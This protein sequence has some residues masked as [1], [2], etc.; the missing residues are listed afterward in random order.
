[1]TAETATSRITPVLSPDDQRR[2]IPVSEAA[3]IIG[4]TPRTLRTWWR[5]GKLAGKEPGRGL[6][7]SREW[8][9]DFVGWEKAS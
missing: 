5:A 8:I 1:M 2:M 7:V 6:L 9:E 3:V 4:K